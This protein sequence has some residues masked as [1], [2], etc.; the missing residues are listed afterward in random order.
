MKANI[1]VIDGKT[2]NS[3]DEMPPD[4]RAKYEQ[5]MKSLKDKGRNDFPDQFENINNMLKDQDGNGITDILEG[6]SSTQ[7][8]TTS[9]RIVINGK[10][11]SSVDQLP[12]DARVR[13]E[14]AMDYM[15]KDRNGIPDFAEDMLEKVRP[16]PC[17][18]PRST[19]PTQPSIPMATSSAITPDTSN[20]WKL[21]LAG[22]ILL[23]VCFIGVAGIWF[24]FLR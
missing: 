20:G 4:V 6:A 7:I 18:K 14:Q 13:Y 1:I 17:Q 5:A 22:V 2:Y 16:T 9:A 10:E 23:F 3:V 8:S 21:V 24:F 11:Y 19:T 15:D 12:S